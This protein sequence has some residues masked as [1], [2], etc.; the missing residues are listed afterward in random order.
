MQPSMIPAVIFAMTAA[1]GFSSVAWATDCDK[2][3]L[4]VTGDAAS[5]ISCIA[6][7]ARSI[8]LGGCSEINADEPQGLVY[9]TICGG[10]IANS[11]VEAEQQ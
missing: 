7:L 10:L 4:D 3:R 1:V 11:F 8:G 9:G 6:S 5:A 2:L